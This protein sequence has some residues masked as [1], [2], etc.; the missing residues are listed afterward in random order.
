MPNSPQTPINFGYTQCGTANELWFGPFTLGA[1]SNKA[2]Y[3]SICRAL[4]IQHETENN[5]FP[6]QTVIGTPLIA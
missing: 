3:F 2:D 6:E 1:M 5:D 4:I